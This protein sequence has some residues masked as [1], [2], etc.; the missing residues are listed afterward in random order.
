MHPFSGGRKF[1]GCDGPSR[2]IEPSPVPE[3]FE[4]ECSDRR[5]SSGGSGPTLPL[6]VQ[7]GANAVL[8][9]DAVRLADRAGADDIEVTLE[10][11]PG[12]P[13]VFQLQY[14]RLDEADAALDRAARFLAAHLRADRSQPVN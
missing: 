7:V 12:L 3:R 5:A 13:H 1:A 11:G 2:R 14:G 10:I 6:L 9:D 4:A 8:L